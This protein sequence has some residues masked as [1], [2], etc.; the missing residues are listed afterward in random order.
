MESG[1]YKI[2]NTL[3]GK[4][5][6]GSSTNIN[7]RLSTHKNLLVKNKH[8]SYKLQRSINK[9]GI[10]KFSFEIIE[11]V[12]FCKEFSTRYKT[13]LLECIEQ[14]YID[15]YDV[16]SNKNYNISPV[17]GKINNPTISYSE[18]TL[19]SWKTRRDNGNN[20]NSREHRYNISKAL[21]NSD[22]FK[23]SQKLNGLKKF[24]KI[25]QYKL[26]GELIKEWS[27]NRELLEYYKHFTLRGL[28][29]A[30]TRT[31]H[32]YKEFIF[33]MKNYKYVR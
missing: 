23:A 9:Y 15:K 19:K 28:Y 26:N 12:Y 17:A 3:N 16:S 8:N 20:I 32:K 13:D 2:T 27:S 18:N 33:L 21:N 14:T 24:K 4:C 6:I 10:D 7:R 5:Y 25:Y 22:K 1:I 11:I 31:N 30:L 29:K